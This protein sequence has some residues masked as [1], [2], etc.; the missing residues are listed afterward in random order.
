MKRGGE[1]R[2]CYLT[3]DELTSEKRMKQARREEATS[4]SKKA[5]SRPRKSVEARRLA[6]PQGGERE[7]ERRGMDFAG[8]EIKQSRGSTT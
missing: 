7:R 1:G 2:G 4:L 5:R 3:R 8:R 6:W